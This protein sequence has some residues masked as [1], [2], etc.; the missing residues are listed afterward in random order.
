MLNPRVVQF[1]VLAIIIILV[2]TVYSFWIYPEVQILELIAKEAGAVLPRTF[3]VVIKD[4]EQEVCIILFLWGTFLCLE[5]L[6]HISSQAYLFD[7]DFLK[8]IENKDIDTTETL[9]A[10]DD[11]PERIK[12]TP[13]VQITT[14]SLRRYVITGSI[15]NAAEVVE[16]ALEGLAIRNEGD[17]AIIKYV[18]WAIPSIG[19]LGTVRGIG[20]AMTQAESA[21]AG[22]I[23]PMTSSLGIAFNSTFVA[24]LVSIFLM[25]L[26]SYLQKS[27]DDQLLKIQDYCERF[28]IRRISLLSKSK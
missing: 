7:V 12:D 1:F 8:E 9:N 13:L 19:F 14:S 6:T 21:V 10:I 20:Q 15:Q 11:L 28:L 27:Q 16:P 4:L 3:I 17:L 24:L 22:D 18:T 5:K 26:L 25:M 23:G 2:H